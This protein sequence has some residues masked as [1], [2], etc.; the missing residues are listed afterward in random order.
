VVEILK[1]EVDT[2]YVAPIEHARGTSVKALVTAI[3][4]VIPDASVKTFASLADAYTQA[5]LDRESCIEQHENDKIVA[6]GSFFTVSS[7][8]QY[9]NEHVNTPL[10]KQ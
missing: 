4:E 9:L 2:W 10:R 8:M 6:F 1:G 3:H 5:Y 7:V